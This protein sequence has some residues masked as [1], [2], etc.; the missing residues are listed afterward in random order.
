VLHSR[1]RIVAALA[2]LTISVLALAQ[3]TVPA[4]P[5][6]SLDTYPE[7]AREA[8]GRA[9]A[10]TTA[11]PLDVEAVATLAK[12]LHAWEQWEGAD[13]AYR[14][15]QELAKSSAAAAGAD[16][17]HLD[18]IVLRRL[19]RFDEA[20]EHFN[21]AS[22]ARPDDLAARV[23][24]AET[25]FEAGHLQESQRAFMQL[26]SEPRA[27]PSAEL[28]LGRIDTA[29]GRHDR[30]VAHFERAIALAPEFGA[31]Y[32]ALALSY[33]ALGRS[34]DAERA[35]TQHGRYGARWPAVED[36][37]RDAVLALRDDGAA[38]L[39][40]GVALSVAGDVTGAIAAHEAAL[41]RDPSLA[42]AHVNLVSLYGRA[43]DYA[44]AEAHYQAAV[45]AGADLTDAHYDYGV[46]LALQEKWDVAADA[47]RQALALNP[48]HVQAHNNLGQVLERQ[49]KFAAAA[50]EYRLALQ[51]QPTFR[52]ARF[53]YGRMLMALGRNDDAVAELA[54]LVE[55]VDA[56]T[57]RYV[58]ALSAAHLRAGR[59]DDAIKWALEARRLAV[60]QG[61]QALVA[62]IDRDLARVK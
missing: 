23:G 60:A 45:A 3:E 9:Y 18:A 56:D 24:L 55:P 17:H 39:R 16:C 28:W 8:I 47:Y 34:A 27:E 50:D 1:P 4:L 25:L 57:P 12:T 19:A 15:C 54:K 6:L 36:P 22:N 44:K 38:I 59:K 14:R 20:A 37:L 42:Q 58:F 41:A 31:A 29:A 26:T 62:I 7:A 13:Q 10:A 52:L 49:Q 2:F 40:R 46:I 61:Q 32:Y 11:R 21:H 5:K 33:R 43:G 30:A 48:A 35:M 53:N 51:A